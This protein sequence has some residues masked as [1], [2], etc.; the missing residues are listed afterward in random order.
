MSSVPVTGLQ[1]VARL[2]N[3][4]CG[5]FAHCQI[6]SVRLNETLKKGA[7]FRIRI[8]QNHTA[9]RSAQFSSKIRHAPAKPGPC[10]FSTRR[11]M[12]GPRL[13]DNRIHQNRTNAHRTSRGCE[14]TLHLTD[15]IFVHL[16]GT[17]ADCL[18][19]FIAAPP[20]KPSL[21][22]GPPSA[23]LSSRLEFQRWQRR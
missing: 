12:P 17:A 14:H 19:V 1:L 21:S 8:V 16:Q 11:E 23:Q 2:S 13:I 18:A 7:V 3:G 6:L 22:T 15:A 9:A 10:R 4:Q 20:Q 5:Q